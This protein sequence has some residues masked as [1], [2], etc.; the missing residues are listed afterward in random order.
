MFEYGKGMDRIEW[1]V[2]DPD[3]TAVFETRLSYT[4]PGAQV[5]RKAGT[6]TMTVGSDREPATGTYRLQLSNAPGG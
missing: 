6:Y 1:K 5:L 2:T 4:E 3:G